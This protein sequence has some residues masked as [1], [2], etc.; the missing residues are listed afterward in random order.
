[1]RALYAMLFDRVPSTWALEKVGHQTP[2]SCRQTPSSRPY[3]SRYGAGADH[4]AKG[5]T[6]HKRASLHGSA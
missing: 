3:A 4:H 6:H 1:M 5:R 2:G